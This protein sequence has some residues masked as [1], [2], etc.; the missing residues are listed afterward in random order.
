MGDKS[1]N[2]TRV[3]GFED[4]AGGDAGGRGGESIWLAAADDRMVMSNWYNIWTRET[5]VDKGKLFF[6]PKNWV[7]GRCEKAGGF[8][9]FLRLVFFGK[10]PPNDHTHSRLRMFDDDDDECDLCRLSVKGDSLFSRQELR[11]YLD[12]EDLPRRVLIEL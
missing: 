9:L 3:D 6:L 12:G 7:T 5:Q 2:G 11:G 8:S 4:E 1:I 10:I